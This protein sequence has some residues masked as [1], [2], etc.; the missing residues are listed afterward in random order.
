MRHKQ[1]EDFQ[2]F[3]ATAG[4]LIKHPP[5]RKRDFENFARSANFQNSSAGG[6]GGTGGGGGGGGG[7]K[8]LA[9]TM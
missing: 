7:G 2:I 1:N 6:G 5:V 8:N 3:A 9:K 4:R